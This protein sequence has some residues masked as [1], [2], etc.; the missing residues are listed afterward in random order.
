MEFGKVLLTEDQIRRR[1]VELGERISRD[2]ADDPPV[3][4]NVLKGGVVFLAD[5]IRAIPLP[6]EIDFMEVSSYGGGTSSTGV[7]RILEDLSINVT[8]RNVLL[9]EDIVDTGHTLQYIID[10]LAT[11]HP[12]SVRI[13]TLLD[14]RGRRETEVPLDYVGFVVPNNFVVGYGLDLAQ[15]YRNL[16]HIAV[17]DDEEIP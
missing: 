17:L 16:P 5:L 12:K 3:L 4:V 13:C 1:V 11:R 8:G 10:N 14:R 7:V 2:Y 9:V 6:V 15:K